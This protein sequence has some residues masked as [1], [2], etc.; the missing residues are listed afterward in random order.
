MMIGH[1]TSPSSGKNV[2]ARDPPNVNAIRTKCDRGKF[3]KAQQL[4][5]Q[6]AGK[7]PS[8]PNVEATRG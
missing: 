1:G 2:V 8:G 6:I 3:G 7:Y 4:F 5:A